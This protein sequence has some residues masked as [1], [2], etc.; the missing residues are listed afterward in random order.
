MLAKLLG[1]KDPIVTEIDGEIQLDIECFSCKT[2][3]FIIVEKS[4]YEAYCAVALVQD[5]FPTLDISSRELIISHT[6]PTCFDE[7]TKESDV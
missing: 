5:A 7:I 3:C 6:C 2:S 1:K 4:Q